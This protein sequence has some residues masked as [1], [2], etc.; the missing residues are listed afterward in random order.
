MVNE[1]KIEKKKLAFRKF[2]LI[3]WV[4]SLLL[5]VV[6]FVLELLNIGVVNNTPIFSVSIPIIAGATSFIFFCLWILH[7]IIKKTK[8]VL[9]VFVVGVLVIA[10]PIIIYGP[11]QSEQRKEACNA[12]YK[13][14]VAEGVWV[15]D[16]NTRSSQVNNDINSLMKTPNPSNITKLIS[17]YGTLRTQNKEFYDRYKAWIDVYSKYMSLFTSYDM[18]S[19]YKSLQ[20]YYT[21]MDEADALYIDTLQ[22]ASGIE[23]SQ[24]LQ[25][26]Y[27]QKYTDANNKIAA[28]QKDLSSAG[29]AL[30]DIENIFS[31]RCYEWFKMN[32]EPPNI[33]K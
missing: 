22:N 6:I 33:N 24:E 16:S 15:Q 5:A 7:L 18:S 20:N 11:R 1:E 21:S 8:A 17:D 10:V 31:A 25:N 14:N 32:I 23:A 28:A 19:I 4:V 3:V 2:C 13:E 12:I 9:I 26:T 30:T 27:N 29:G